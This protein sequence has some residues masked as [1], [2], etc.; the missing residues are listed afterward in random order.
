MGVAEGQTRLERHSTHSCDNLEG[1]DG[2]GGGRRAQEG[3]E[4][5][6]PVADAC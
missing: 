2:V 6:V 3:A 4:M 1:W 5:C